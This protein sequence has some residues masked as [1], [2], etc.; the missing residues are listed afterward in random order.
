MNMCEV[1]NEHIGSHV[2]HIQ[3]KCFSGKNDKSNKV[4]LCPLCHERV[5]SKTN[6]LI[7]E[8]KFLTTTGY[9]LFFH[10]KGE[11]SI[12]GFEPKCYVQ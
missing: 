8:G 2:H 10:K 5:H 1:C 4:S 6:T 12:T 3:S 9:K 11:E 7:L